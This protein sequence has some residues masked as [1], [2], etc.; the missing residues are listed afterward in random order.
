[1][2]QRRAASSPPS[3]SRANSSAAAV[4]LVRARSSAAR[5]ALARAAASN[6]QAALVRFHSG[7]TRNST[8]ESGGEQLDEP[9]DQVSSSALASPL[10]S[11]EKRALRGRARGGEV[12]RRRSGPIMGVRAAGDGPDASP[13]LA[14]ARRQVALAAGPAQ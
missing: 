10:R 11:V 14:V 12:A 7:G 9:R 8:A 6:R 3:N 4:L 5:R 1:M 2:R 13:A